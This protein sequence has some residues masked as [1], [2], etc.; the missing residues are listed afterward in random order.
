MRQV[1]TRRQLP[2]VAQAS[3]AALAATA[4]FSMSI[5]RIAGGSTF[6]PKGVHRFKTHAAANLQDEAWLAEGIARLAREREHG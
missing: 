5:A 2:I 3:G 4:L 6:V 1:G